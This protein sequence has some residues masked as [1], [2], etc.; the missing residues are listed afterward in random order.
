[1]IYQLGLTCVDEIEQLISNYVAP[2]Q[3]YRKSSKN[4]FF[5]YHVVFVL[6]CR[7]FRLGKVAKTISR[8]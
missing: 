6:L 3:F 8:F 5:E 7:F 2:S 4:S 1:M